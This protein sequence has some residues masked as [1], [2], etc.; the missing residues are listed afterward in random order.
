VKLLFIPFSIVGGLIA[1]FLGKK[2]FEGAWG[3]VDD[4]EPPQAEHRYVSFGKVV[5]AAALEGAI[6][7]AVRAG[8]DHQSRRA[9]A[10]LTGSWPGKEEP[11]AE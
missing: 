7:R 11:E 5:L 2:L 4:Q 9:F 3:L 8:V 10:G 1:G 6:F